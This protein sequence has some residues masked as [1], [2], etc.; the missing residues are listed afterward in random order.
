MQSFQHTGRN[1]ESRI[2]TRLSPRKQVG[3]VAGSAAAVG[4]RMNDR[5]GPGPAERIDREGPL[6]KALDGV[7]VD[8][9][10]TTTIQRS[11][12]TRAHATAFAR[13]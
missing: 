2:A 6:R 4:V 10:T 9:S 1:K 3:Y 13:E 8:H 11:G 5:I 7:D 12:V